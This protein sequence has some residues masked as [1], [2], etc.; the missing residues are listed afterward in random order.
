[1]SDVHEDTHEID[2]GRSDEFLQVRPDFA[3][4][5]WVEQQPR[6][7]RRFAL[8][9]LGIEEDSPQPPPQFQ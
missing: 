6:E 7:F 3:A 1:M 9:D 4:A 2:V 8:F 5:L